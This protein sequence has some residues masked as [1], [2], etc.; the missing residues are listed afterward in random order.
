MIQRYLGFC[1]FFPQAYQKCCLRLHP[2]LSVEH[3]IALLCSVDQVVSQHFYSG[4]LTALDA[5]G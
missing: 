3:M 5:P 2:H 1:F 4:D